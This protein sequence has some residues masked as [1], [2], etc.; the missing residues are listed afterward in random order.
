MLKQILFIL[1][2]ILVTALV[3]EYFAFK[4]QNA[5]EKKHRHEISVLKRDKD[6]LEILKSSAEQE[7]SRAK[8]FIQDLEE[9]KK[10]AIL[11][12]PEIEA[13][14]RFKQAKKEAEAFLEQYPAINSIPP[15]YN[16]YPL[17]VKIIDNYAILS[18]EAKTQTNIDLEFLKQQRDCAFSDYIRTTTEYMQNADSKLEGIP[19]HLCQLTQIMEWFNSV[20][21]AV[22]SEISGNVIISLSMKEAHAKYL[23]GLAAEAQIPDDFQPHNQTLLN[24]FFIAINSGS[25][26]AKKSLGKWFNEKKKAIENWATTP[27]S[28]NFPEDVC[29][30]DEILEEKQENE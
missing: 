21:V 14:V 17:L 19:E 16:N 28:H 26:K 3:S 1:F 24:K 12:N 22:R 13:L 18:D 25:Q 6:E 2:A 15:T 10:K 20:P 9:W 4:K 7:L 11:C 30:E 27:F 23:T 8:L 29:E 5:I